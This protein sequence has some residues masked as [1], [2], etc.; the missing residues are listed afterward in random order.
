[1]ITYTDEQYE[2]IAIKAII[3]YKNKNYSDNEVRKLYSLAIPLV[4]ENIKKSLNVDKN[5]AS[6]TQGS[7]SVSYKDTYSII[8]D[9]VKM[10]VGLP[11]V[12]MY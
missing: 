1:M 5:V 11:Y 6:M 7:R 12:R 3:E 2:Q 10:L 8:D 9:S 4:I